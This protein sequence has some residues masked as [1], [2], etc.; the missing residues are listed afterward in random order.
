M[1]KK[2]LKESLVMKNRRLKMKKMACFITMA[3]QLK[4]TQGN[5][6]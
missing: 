5:D 1:H 6:D 3:S 4:R 2:H